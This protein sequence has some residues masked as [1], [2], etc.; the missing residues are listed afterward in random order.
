MIRTEIL[1]PTL[2]YL[3]CSNNVGGFC[4]PTWPFLN[5]ASCKASLQ[6]ILV[7]NGT[8]CGRTYAEANWLVWGSET[9]ALFPSLLH[10]KKKYQQNPHVHQLFCV[11]GHVP[12]ID[13]GGNQSQ[14]HMEIVC[15]YQGPNRIEFTLQYT[16]TVGH[17]LHTTLV[18]FVC[19]F[20]RFN[21]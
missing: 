6:S 3:V 5:V 7:A 21:S 1:T 12:H 14:L 8:R 17:H 20:L 19:R 10:P 16:G 2:A 9:Q 11:L 18:C 15:I 13:T 4:L